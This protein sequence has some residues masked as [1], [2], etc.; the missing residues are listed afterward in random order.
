MGCMLRSDP[1][2][3]C[4]MYLQPEAA[5]EVIGHLGDMECVQF[6]DVSD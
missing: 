5:F 2:T 3:F 1:M 6:V 4:D